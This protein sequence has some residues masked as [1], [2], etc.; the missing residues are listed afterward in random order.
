MT[1]R[2][3]EGERNAGSD[4]I[5]IFD[6]RY[7]QL[8]LRFYVK[9]ADDFGFNHHFTSLSGVVDPKPAPGG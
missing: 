8:F 1:I 4:L 3:E 9:F 7:E 6:D 5:K 2:R